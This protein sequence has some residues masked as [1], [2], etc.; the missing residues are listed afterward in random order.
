MLSEIVIL[1]SFPVILYK[2]MQNIFYVGLILALKP[3][4]QMLFIK[5]LK[6]TQNKI[7]IYLLLLVTFSLF[8]VIVIL[9]NKISNFLILPV[10]LILL[11]LSLSIFE[12]AK[13]AFMKEKLESEKS[14]DLFKIHNIVNIFAYILGP[15]FAINLI[16]KNDYYGI[17]NFFAILISVAGIVFYFILRKTQKQLTSISIEVSGEQK[18]FKDLIFTEGVKGALMFVIPLYVITY[19]SGNNS[20]IWAIPVLFSSSLIIKILFGVFKIR[21]RK[22]NE[23]VRVLMLCMVL[24]S[25]FF[26]SDHNYFIFACGLLGI[27]LAVI[28][29]E[30]SYQDRLKDKSI[31]HY[32]TSSIAAA[33]GI[34]LVAALSSF[35]PVNTSLAALGVIIIAFDFGLSV[36]KLVQKKRIKANTVA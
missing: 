26:S 18:I 1:Y 25:F 33:I 12:I 31:E 22:I 16:L 6:R 27:V 7:N 34:V 20:V 32:L 23:L 28:E 5:F 10:I 30:S 13:I 19:Y 9:F 21:F 2:G 8:Y 14:I 4:M 17:F 35:Y 11:G 3:I 36:Y 15:I 24:M 29:N